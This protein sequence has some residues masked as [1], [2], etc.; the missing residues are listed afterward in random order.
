MK[1][2]MIAVLTLVM[3]MSSL[4]FA[5][6]RGNQG[7]P[8]ATGLERAE[9]VAN[10]KGVSKGI[11]TVR[12]KAGSAQ[13]EGSP[14]SR[15]RTRKARVKLAPSSFPRK[16][17]R[18]PTFFSK[19]VR[20]ATCTMGKGEGRI[21]RASCAEERLAR[22]NPFGRLFSMTSGQLHANTNSTKSKHRQC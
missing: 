21:F 6:G 18:L 8:A 5:Q 22:V 12:S 2:S 19:I 13:N 20:Y 17:F 7:K 11:D 15:R 10:P 4:T 16:Q 1:R 3:G 9:Q 14:R